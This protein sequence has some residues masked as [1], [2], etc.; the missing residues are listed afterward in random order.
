M[1]PLL[2]TSVPTTS[3]SDQRGDQAQTRVD[4]AR[5]LTNTVKPVVKTKE[6]SPTEVGTDSQADV[7]QY[8]LRN[9]ASHC[10][11]IIKR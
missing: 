3:Y 8:G 7:E 1:L 6:V 5:K 4:D 11:M 9:T 10:T 2:C